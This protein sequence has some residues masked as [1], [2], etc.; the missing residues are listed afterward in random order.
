MPVNRP[1]FTID[2][3][4][5]RAIQ[6]DE[7]PGL[8]DERIAE[9]QEA[10]NASMRRSVERMQMLIHPRVPTTSWN[11][12]FQGYYAEDMWGNTVQPNQREL[13]N[14]IRQ[15]KR[16]EKPFILRFLQTGV[17]P[18]GVEALYSQRF[19]LLQ[20]VGKTI[21]RAEVIF[22]LQDNIIVANQDRT[23]QIRKEL[24]AFAALQGYG[25]EF[26]PGGIR[27]QHYDYKV[28]MQRWPKKQEV[29][30]SD[31]ITTKVQEPRLINSAGSEGGQD[32]E[33]C[34]EECDCPR[35]PGQ[36]DDEPF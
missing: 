36:L 9:V 33:Y 3:G 19:K 14:A 6:M 35:H 10:T 26:V 21:D 32:E 25:L 22:T 30:D 4:M 8:S 23:N 5:V 12:G 28:V 34:C 16:K 17:A 1:T 11:S 15:Q 13:R 24:E 7:A 31:L 20:L 29:D 27:M 18:Q 2:P